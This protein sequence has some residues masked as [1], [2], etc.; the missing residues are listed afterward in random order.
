LERMGLLERASHYPTQLSGGEQQRA[1]IARA[2]INGPDLVFCDEPTGNLDEET[3]GQVFEL[4]VKFN[5]EDGQTFLIVT[6]EESL[7][8]KARR[9][10][11]LHEGR[12]SAK[13]S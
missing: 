12:L 5:R 4:L 1:A 2:L 3:A 7:I 13:E 6:H 8:R 9:V 10:Y 11:H